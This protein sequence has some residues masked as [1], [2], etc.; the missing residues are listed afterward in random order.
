VTGG[1]VFTHLARLTDAVG[2]FEHAEGTMPR[3][4]HGYCVDDVARALVVTARQPDPGPDVEGLSEIYLRF[5][6]AAQHPS[7]RFHNRRTAAGVWVDAPSLGDWW[8]RA[9]WGLGTAAARSPAHADEALRRFSAGADHRA[10]WSRSMCFAALGA[11]EVLS[12]D[13]GHRSARALLR[14]A[15][16]FVDVAAGDA[17]WPWPEP[18]LRYANAVVPEVL[19][20]AGV[21]L[22]VPRWTDEGLRVLGWLLDTETRD[23][24]LSV[25]P[26]GGWALG[27]SRPG[28]DQQPIE[29]AALG[30]ACA[31]AY[32]VTG[33]RD[34]SD[35]V[36]R[37]AAWFDGDNDAQTPM[38][39]PQ[40][41]GGF[42]GLE[43]FGRNEN[44]GAESTLA[45]LSTRQQTHRLLVG[46]R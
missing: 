16:R 10:P 24:H 31:R 21:L 35:S 37:C 23:G 14:D 15:A 9:L 6:A 32:A 13:P 20:E 33:D 5:L 1:V 18:R 39:D 25:V 8:G 12:A 26:A 42:D 7:G 41:G 27:E 17:S 43:P 3:L 46:A 36:I 19:I 29:V 28:F 38:S 40:T 44:Q 11:A 45:L 22:D 2:L 4:E 34:W 30:D